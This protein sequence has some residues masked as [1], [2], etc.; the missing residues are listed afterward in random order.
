MWISSGLLKAKSFSTYYVLNALLDILEVLFL[1]LLTKLQGG[2][3]YFYYTADIERWVLWFL[4]NKR[5]CKVG[6][7]IS[8]LSM[9]LGDG[10]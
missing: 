2:Y 4:L 8:I 7:M 1:I 9:S 6:N 5:D 10:Y 3:Y